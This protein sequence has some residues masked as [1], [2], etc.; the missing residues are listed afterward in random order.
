M[1]SALAV[2]N[3]VTWLTDYAADK[4]QADRPRVAAIG[5]DQFAV[6]WERWTGTGDRQSTFVG[7][8]GLIL[9]A[10]GA[11]KQA[12]QQLGTHHLSRGDDVV[13]LGNR[14]LFVSGAGA[15]KKLTLNL[16]SADLTLT[17]IDLP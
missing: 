4:A 7:V 1:S 9:G 5:D 3:K 13:A 10:D 16:V 14:A 11:I 12:P 8:Q 6:L 17:A 15:T 2:T